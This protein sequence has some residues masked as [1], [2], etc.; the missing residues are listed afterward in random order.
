MDENGEKL[1]L[2][3]PIYPLLSSPLL[4]SPG[5]VPVEDP[6][7]NTH[8][9]R[10]VTKLTNKQTGKTVGTIKQTWILRITANG[11]KG[12]YQFFYYKEK[13][14]LTIIKIH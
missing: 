3:L 11:K 1:F 10:T 4:S 7:F 5:S 2:Q 14:L 12:F 8:I 6:D 9:L 13:L